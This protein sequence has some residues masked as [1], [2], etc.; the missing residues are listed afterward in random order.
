MRDRLDEC[1]ISTSNN[2]YAIGGAAASIDGSCYADT[3]LLDPSAR[4][5]AS[6]FKQH[7]I[8][9]NHVVQVYIS[10]DPYADEFVRTIDLKRIRCIITYSG[11]GWF[12]SDAV[13]TIMVD[14]ALNHSPNNILSREFDT[15][16]DCTIR[17][18]C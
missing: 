10:T 15:S 3:A 6:L 14:D 4:K 9:K 16:D 13:M 7:D 17:Q 5:C 18:M 11:C 2:N 1:S 8:S 12:R